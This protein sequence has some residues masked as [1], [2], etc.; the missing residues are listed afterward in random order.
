M[1]ERLRWL[2]KQEDIRDWFFK[3]LEAVDSLNL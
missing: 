1:T 2:I 3:Q